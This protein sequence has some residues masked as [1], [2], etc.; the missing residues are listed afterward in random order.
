LAVEG[1]AG[2]A[3]VTL[4][5]SYGQIV[6]QKET[7]AGIIQIDLQPGVYFLNIRQAAA[8][9]SFAVRLVKR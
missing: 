4:Y 8:K 6:Y 9:K 3:N 5:N 7:N 1:F 2:L